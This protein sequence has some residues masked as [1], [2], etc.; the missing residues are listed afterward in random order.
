MHKVYF[1]LCALIEQ[2]IYRY[3]WNY[4]CL[5]DT[6]VIYLSFLCELNIMQIFYMVLCIFVDSCQSLPKAFVRF[7]KGCMRL[8]EVAQWLN[9]VLLGLVRFNDGSTL[10][11]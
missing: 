7:C 9:E 1:K 2:K 5:Q 4:W 3:F 11:L 8:Y 6:Y 10:A